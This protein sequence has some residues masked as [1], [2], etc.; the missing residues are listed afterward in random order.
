MDM[1][2]N[3]LI[4]IIIIISLFD[5]LFCLKN[6]FN[7]MGFKLGMMQSEVTN[8]IFQNTNLKIDESRFF[9]K[10][11]EAVP[12]IIKATYLPYIDNIYTQFYS[13]SCYGITIQF[14][15]GYFD[16]FTL[17]E[18]LEDK[19]GPPS[20]KTSKLVLWENIQNTNTQ[21]DIKLRLE[22]PST[23][24]VFDKNIVILINSEL[25]RNFIKMTNESVIESIKKAL[26]GE[27]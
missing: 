20:L 11:N 25:S 19:Y 1:K 21:K 26:L 10:I 15:P 14:D 6:E 8:I 24:K 23:V 3:I 16:F 27:L 7:F 5:N 2:R 9:G 13:N 18:T 22:Y 4:L 12:F 17:S